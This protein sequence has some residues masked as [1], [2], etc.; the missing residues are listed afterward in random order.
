MQIGI[1]AI[2]NISGE[3]RMYVDKI[4]RDL[5]QIESTTP[6]IYYH[7]WYGRIFFDHIN[8]VKDALEQMETGKPA[9]IIFLWF[10]PKEGIQYVRL[11]GE[12]DT[13]FTEGV[14]IYGYYQ[15]MTKY[16]LAKKEK[17][18]FEKIY[19]H[20]IN[21]LGN[22]Y[23]GIHLVH[24]KTDEVTLIRTSITGKKQGTKMQLQQYFDMLQ[25]WISKENIAEIKN[26]IASKKDCQEEHCLFS[27]EYG[28]RINGKKF[29]FNITIY[30]EEIELEHNIVV[31]Y[32]DITKQKEKEQNVE[33]TIAYLKAQSETDGLTGLKNR[34]TFEQDVNLY[35][36]KQLAEDEIC[37]F[38]LLDLDFFKNVN[39]YFGHMK[40]D[41]LLIEVA[42]ILRCKCRCDDEIARLGGDEFVI[43]LKNIKSRENAEALANRILNKMRRSYK[44]EDGKKV[45]VSASVGIVFAPKTGRDFETLYNHADKALYC[46][47][48]NG[49]G[50]YTIL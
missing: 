35:L 36:Q 38:M 14:R 29:W 20:I 23:Q 25:K 9:E 1:W 50:R 5:L 48:N 31:A 24:T 8:M 40:G 16:I 45:H 27:K 15:N 10:H 46:S 49:K 22:M 13:S 19:Y 11:G 17:E 18:H 42:D 34:K 2:E 33:D 28:Q 4:M 44:T 43:F 12:R 30:M 37:A 26:S 3:F 32:R 21:T 39:D 6:Q 41:M 47:K 7:N